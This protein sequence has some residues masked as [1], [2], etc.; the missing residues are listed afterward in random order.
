VL[1][2]PQ[3]KK[4]RRKLLALIGP[5]PKEVRL[6]L[7]VFCEVYEEVQ[8]GDTTQRGTVRQRRLKR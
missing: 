7:S 6:L 4:H 1:E 5:T 2:Y 8:A 3:L